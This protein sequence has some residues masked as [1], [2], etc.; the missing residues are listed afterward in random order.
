MT[1]NDALFS[2]ASDNWSTPQWFLDELNEEFHFTLDACASKDNAKCEN[3]FD[4]EMDALKQVWT[5]NVWLN[6]PYSRPENACK[7]NCKKKK[8]IQRGYH[9]D[10]YKYGQID[11]VAKAYSSVFVD[12]TAD[13]V[14]CLIPSRTDT[15]LWFSYVWDGEKHCPKNGV[16][17]RFIAGRL[18]F[19]DAKDAAPFPS[20]CT[21]FRRED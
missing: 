21:I 17:V 12:K 4:E 15:E 11:F 8:C 14:V 7:P 9:L 6:P 3:Y 18:K 13:L 20:C 2:S 5:G 10:T 16:E 19:G 1:I